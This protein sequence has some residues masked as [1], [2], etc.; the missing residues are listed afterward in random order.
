MK[1]EE[2]H[3]KLQDIFRDVFEEDDLIIK[4]ETDADSIEEWDSLI[5]VSLIA[6]I[7]SDFDIRFSVGE[8][9]ELK[10]VGEMV[11]LITQKIS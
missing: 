11:S 3:S 9:G 8:I 1:K 10:D 6:N 7:E 4:D 5:H 2:V